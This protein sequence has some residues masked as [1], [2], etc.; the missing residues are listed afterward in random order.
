MAT[1]APA[2]VVTD[3]STPL[4]VIAKNPDTI[5]LFGHI[6]EVL[7][8]MV[9]LAR[10]GYRVFPGIVP[11]IYHLSGTVS[12]LLQRGEPLAL[13]VQRANES[14]ARE[15]KAEAA[16]F[17]KRVQE[18]AQRIAAQNAQRD[19]EARVAA[20]QAVADE[21]VARIRADA[22]AAIARITATV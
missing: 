6:S 11:T 19:L 8:E 2:T 12:I 3:E 9:V 15:Q 4:D 13:A 17:D 22:E 18:E 14:I 5:K 10:S 21:Q 7:D 16:L 20:A 1:K